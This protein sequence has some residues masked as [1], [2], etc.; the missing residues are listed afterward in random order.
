[1][2]AIEVHING[3]KRFTVG[4]EDYQS[5]NALLGLVRLPLPKPNDASITFMASAITPGGEH[6]AMW[7]NLEVTIGDRV[8]IR[9]VDVETVDAPETVQTLEKSDDT[10]A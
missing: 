2:L 1:M 8:E 5:V 9:V 4:G 7:P 10:D 6:V 3:Q